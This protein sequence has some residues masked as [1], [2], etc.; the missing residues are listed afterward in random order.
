MSCDKYKDQDHSSLL[1]P[2]PCPGQSCI[3]LGG[4]ISQL[5]DH[6]R[7]FAEHYAR[8]MTGMPNS[9][10]RIY[11][12]TCDTRCYDKQNKQ[13]FGAHI[14]LGQVECPKTRSCLW[15]Q[16]PWCSSGELSNV[17][18]AAELG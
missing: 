10:D 6:T 3:I 11:H 18:R 17:L 1:Q 14:L 16:M 12:C 4:T 5:A 13:N 7:Q 9:N 8:L 15:Q 2:L